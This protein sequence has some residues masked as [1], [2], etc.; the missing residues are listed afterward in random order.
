MSAGAPYWRLGEVFRSLVV[1]AIPS[2]A[3]IAD[4]DLATLLSLDDVEFVRAAYRAALRR[5]PDPMGEAITSPYSVRD[6]I[7]NS[8][9][10][11]MLLS[12]RD[13]RRVP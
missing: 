5:E 9:L 11:D 8:I 2:L 7:A 12:R 1:G 3:G 6:T 4:T 10:L 13:S